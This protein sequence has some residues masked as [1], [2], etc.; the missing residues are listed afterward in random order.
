MDAKRLDYIESLFSPAAQKCML[1][2][3]HVHEALGGACEVIT[4][5]RERDAEVAHLR[6][7]FGLLA[8]ESVRHRR[9]NMHVCMEKQCRN[10]SGCVECIC[11][12][13]MEATKEQPA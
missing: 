8:K 10:D 5:Y 13:Y 3:N 11:S 7:A 4:A 2:V 9:G 12:M 6:R 1:K